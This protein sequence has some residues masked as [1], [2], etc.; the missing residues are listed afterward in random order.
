MTDRIWILLASEDAL[1]LQ[2]KFF[3]PLPG[4]NRPVDA[5]LVTDQP[6]DIL[7]AAQRGVQAAY[8]SIKLHGFDIPGLAVGFDLRGIT[9]KRPIIGSSA[10]LAFALALA[11]KRL[12]I[13]QDMAATGE[14]ISGL[15]DGEVGKVDEIRSKLKASEKFLVTGGKVF[16]PR[17]N[18][19]EIDE[20]LKRELEIKDI[21]LVPVD[22]VA[23]AVSYLIEQTGNGVPP[24]QGP[25]AKQSTSSSNMH[26]AMRCVLLSVLVLL[27]V[28]LW[29]A[30]WK[31]EDMPTGQMPC[32]KLVLVGEDSLT[33]KLIDNL[34]S[35]WKK[36]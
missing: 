15:G 27:A 1:P 14:V 11:Q 19:S 6:P 3:Q 22:S 32:A 29:R 13:K 9:A 8:Q 16:F 24:A 35:L 20:D 28:L 18:C 10:G 2:T 31:A 33:Q 34:V 36:R 26:I 25:I 7:E 12:G 30:N 23:E 5:F 4:T 21:T 17:A